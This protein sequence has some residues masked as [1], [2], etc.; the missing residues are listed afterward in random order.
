MSDDFAIAVCYSRL[1]RIVK[2][3]DLRNAAKRGLDAFYELL[4][5]YPVG[6]AIMRNDLDNPIR[7]EKK[8][9]RY[10]LAEA[11]LWTRYDRNNKAFHR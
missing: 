11:G 8:L 9:Y 3:E 5:K 4:R 2:P 10:L 1:S 7:F 6:Q